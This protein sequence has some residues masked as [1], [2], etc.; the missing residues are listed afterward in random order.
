[1]PVDLCRILPTQ[2]FTQTPEIKNAI[3]H[4]LLK[5]PFVCNPCKRRMHCCSFTK[6]IYQSK[7]AQDEYEKLLPTSIGYPFN[8]GII[9]Y[10]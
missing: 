2:L 3:C 7:F 5:A 4:I 1:L 9:L 10:Y 8:E 6:Q